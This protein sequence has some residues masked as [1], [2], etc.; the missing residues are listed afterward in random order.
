MKAAFFFSILQKDLSY[1]FHASF[2]EFVECFTAKH[3]V[4]QEGKVNQLVN[5]LVVLGGLGNN[6]LLLVLL[7]IDSLLRVAQVVFLVL[8]HFLW[9]LLVLLL[10][11]NG[12]AGFLS[13]DLS[14]DRLQGFLGFGGFI[15]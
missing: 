12:Q 5:N 10:T 2:E 4:L 9:L 3:T 14:K 11:E 8:G 7:F 15:G 6:L 13:L 1:Q